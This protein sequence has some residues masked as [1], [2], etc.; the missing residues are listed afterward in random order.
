MPP[1]PIPTANIVMDF[2]DRLHY[3]QQLHHDGGGDN[4]CADAN[5]DDSGDQVLTSD[6]F[7]NDLGDVDV[8]GDE[9]PRPRLS[10]AT[11]AHKISSPTTKTKK[12][13]KIPAYESPAISA[14]GRDS[15]RSLSLTGLLELSPPPPPPGASPGPSPVSGKH[16]HRRLSA[17]TL[18]EKIGQRQQQSPS[19]GSVRRFGRSMT[20]DADTS[21][22]TLL[23]VKSDNNR[24][25][26]VDSG[27]GTAMP[28]TPRS[29]MRRLKLL[30]N[31][32]ASSVSNMT[33]PELPPVEQPPKQLSVA[34]KRRLR[35]E[36]LS[37][38]ASEAEGDNQNQK[39]LST[40][41]ENN[42]NDV[43]DDPFLA[44]G[45]RRS[46][47]N[48]GSSDSSNSNSS[49]DVDFES[50]PSS[51]V[52][53]DEDGDKVKIKS[54]SAQTRSP[55]VRSESASSMSIDVPN[56]NSSF[57]S[58][59]MMM[60]S[61]ST[62]SSTVQPSSSSSGELNSR[63]DASMTSFGSKGKKKGRRPSKVSTES[64]VSV[65]GSLSSSDMSESA[66]HLQNYVSEVASPVIG[67]PSKLK[68][69]TSSLKENER[70]ASIITESP[71]R[72]SRV[73]RKA[74]S[75]RGGSQVR[76]RSVPRNE[77]VVKQTSDVVASTDAEEAPSRK[78]STTK[79]S[80]RK[81]IETT[82]EL[83]VASDHVQS[84]AMPPKSPMRNSRKLSDTKPPRCKSS[85]DIPVLSS[86]APEPT[87]RP[88]AVER[89][90]SK[91]PRSKNPR[92]KVKY[93]RSTSDP[94]NDVMDL[95]NASK[96]LSIQLEF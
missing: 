24:K 10:R 23:S 75:E 85:G 43:T 60:V 29:R 2:D 54:Q 64:A 34:E 70:N 67:K 47:S 77:K 32:H 92:R 14:G 72:P 93:H 37:N 58:G 41:A 9:G 26:V 65:V 16:R 62:I 17:V 45:S 35:N 94:N 84:T 59:S 83:F 7:G 5:V 20:F 1:I 80:R 52:N 4:T 18:R 30:D 96:D 56:N 46:Q 82:S 33:A 28:N 78:A 15:K 27:I 50:S 53:Q 49:E 55:L 71:P 63:F 95:L 21:H 36:C 31:M 90:M 66:D 19:T 86:D 25:P 6:V 13:K 48:H 87:R 51:S 76:G 40:T 79:P 42:Q 74:V 88:S 8:W 3:Q 11:T 61:N 81:C 91:S 22:S 44:I 73:S 69:K 57:S 68:K 12:G 39:H 89:K 38:R